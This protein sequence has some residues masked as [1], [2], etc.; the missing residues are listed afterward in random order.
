MLRIVVIDKPWARFGPRMMNF[1]INPDDDRPENAMGSGGRQFGLW[2]IFI[3][4]VR[5]GLRETGERIYSS[6]SPVR[7]CELAQQVWTVACL[8]SD[9]RTGTDMAEDIMGASPVT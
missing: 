6:E 9:R 8:I 4:R 2:H 1:V 7:C 5:Q 3:D